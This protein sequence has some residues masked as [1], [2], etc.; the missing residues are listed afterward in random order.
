MT[1]LDN[2]FSKKIQKSIELNN[3]LKSTQALYRTVTFVRT[4][5]D[6]YPNRTLSCIVSL[7]RV[8]G[9]PCHLAIVIPLPP[10]RDDGIV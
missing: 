6:V 3:R 1:W 9:I 2:F 5:E 4:R 8:R 7:S 10:V